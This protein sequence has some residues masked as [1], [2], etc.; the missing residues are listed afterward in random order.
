M[1]KDKTAF[2]EEMQE[3]GAKGSTGFNKLAGGLLDGRWKKLCSVMDEDNHITGIGIVE[4]GAWVDKSAALVST[5]DRLYIV[6]KGAIGYKVSY[7]SYDDIHSIEEN[8]FSKHKMKSLK[9]IRLVLAVNMDGK[10]VKR[11][12]TMDS[13]PNSETFIT[14][15]QKSYKTYKTGKKY[16][17]AGLSVNGKSRADL[18]LEIKQLYETGALSEEE[19]KRE[20]SKIMRE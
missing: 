5:D 15:L 14:N 4:N 20:K 2:L 1:A 18:L 13:A 19:Y 3:A 11:T 16:A 9:D 7:I 8:N 17:E 6:N 10:I 12:C